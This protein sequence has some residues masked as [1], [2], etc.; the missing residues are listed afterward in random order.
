MT[1]LSVVVDAAAAFGWAGVLF[2]TFVYEL[3][4]PAWLHPTGGTRLQKLLLQPSPAVV[5]A[6]E[7]IAEEMDS[8]DER[9]VMELF[10]EDNLHTYDLKVQRDNG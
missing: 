2:G 5:T 1:V 7:A 8:L 4:F 10:H 9:A 6:L 3:F